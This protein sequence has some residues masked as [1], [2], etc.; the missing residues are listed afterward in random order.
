[1]NTPAHVIFSLSLLG[2]T[3]AARFALP[4]TAGALLPDVLMVL[5][6]IYEKM[7]G[8]PEHIIWHQHYFLPHWQTVFDLPNSFPLIAIGAIIAWR[9]RSAAWIC[10]FAS[11]SVHCILDLLVHHDDGHRHFFPL[12]DFRFQSPVSYWD[13]AHYGGI[14][15]VLEV[16][17]VGAGVI[18]LWLAEQQKAAVVFPLTRLRQ[19]VLLVT[20]IYAAFMV[21][22]V[23]SWSA[24]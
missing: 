14:V 18:Y 10:L 11:M 16:L 9:I 22:A 3:R 2:R 5:F 13:P 20:A 19:V 21:F 8:V 12:S 6:Y 4:I 7:L 17:L 15:S 1:M 23:F 24:G